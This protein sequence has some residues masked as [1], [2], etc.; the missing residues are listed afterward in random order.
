M[1]VS[2]PKA[3]FKGP[4][5]PKG[6]T[7]ENEPDEFFSSGWGAPCFLPMMSTSGLLKPSLSRVVNGMTEPLKN[8]PR[9]SMKNWLDELCSS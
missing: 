3:Q 2:P 8:S 4:D 6:L 5:E 1:R 9:V 7:R